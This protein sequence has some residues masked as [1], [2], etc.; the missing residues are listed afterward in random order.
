[1][2]K[3]SNIA[4]QGTGLLILSVLP[5]IVGANPAATRNTDE[6][7]GPQWPA[8]EA[9]QSACHPIGD[10]R[11]R[12]GNIFDLDDPTEDRFLFRVANR[13]HTRTQPD[14]IRSQL[15]FRPDQP[16]TLQQIEESERLLRSNRYIQSAQ[17]TPTLGEDGRVDI[18]VVTTDVWTLIPKLSFSRAGGRNELAV[19]IKEMNLFGT[20]MSVELQH[21]NL[22]DRDST[23]LKFNDGN[24]AGSRYAIRTLL[25]RN[26]DGDQAFLNLGKPFYALDSRE[27][28]GFRFNE[29][30]QVESFY[31]GGQPVA[32]FRHEAKQLD[33]YLGWSRGLRDGWTKR[34]TT[35]ITVDEHRFADAPQTDF[36]LLALPEDRKFVYPWI[37]LELVEDRFEKTTNHS[38]I[39]RTEDRF[40]GTRF[41]ARLG[42]A[43]PAIG[44]VDEALFVDVSAQKGFGS[45]EH[46]SLIIGADLA[47][48]IAAGATEDVLLELHAGYS[49]RQSP[50]RL[51][52]VGFDAS[53]GKN[54]D[55]DRQLSLGGETGLRGYPLRYQSGSRKAL[56]SVEQ[57]F[58]TDWYPFRL[59]HIGGAVFFDLGRA[60][61]ETP[62]PNG[63]HGWLRDI[64]AG[65]RLGDARSGLGRMTHIDVAYP[66][67]GGRDISNLQFL[68]ST[69]KSF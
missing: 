3:L 63:E 68:I 9:L 59:F 34:L 43:S 14:V 2:L 1:M 23:A 22:V 29:F 42:A 4:V 32:D 61:G 62:V 7:A 55:I 28:N 67:D 39:S 58:F 11:I 56:F 37:G 17:I 64:G 26:S 18:D 5:T 21:A 49:R 69:R 8:L 12:N 15:L 57:R 44:S 53:I 33:M 6:V 40:L 20:G 27:A 46:D 47:A 31:V 38:Q 41:S 16:L 35:G 54:L 51:L 24:I 45:T 30:D 19:G 13:L 36:P 25:A 65:L 50:H 60:W 10:I 52:H 66:I 48:R